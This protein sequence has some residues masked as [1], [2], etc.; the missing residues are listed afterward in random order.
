MRG[1]VF[2]GAIAFALAAAFSAMTNAMSTDVTSAAGAGSRFGVVIPPPSTLAKNQ[3]FLEELGVEWYQDYGLDMSNVPSGANKIALVRMSTNST[4]WTSGQAEAIGALA[5]DAIVSLG[6]ADPAEVRQTATS[7]PGTYWQVSVE[8]NVRAEVTGARFAPV[9]RF[10][11]DQIVNADPTAKIIGPAILNWDFTCIGC[12]GYQSGEAW[13]MEFIGA[14]EALFGEKPP[15]DAW[16]I[17]AYPI[18]WTNTP[19][20]DPDTSNQPTWKGNKVTHSGIV[21]DQLQGMRQY[22]DSIPQYAE[23]PIWA[24]QVGV[25]VGYT[26]WTFE[27]GQIVSQGVYRWDLMSDFVH[28]VLDWLDTN[29]ETDNIGRWLFYIAW[30]D[31]VNLGFTGYM[32]P[33]FF[34]GPGQGASL[35]CLGEVYR[36]RALGLPRLDCDTDG[37]LIGQPVPSGPTPTPTPTATATPTPTPVPLTSVWTLLTL[38]AFFVVLVPFQ[39]WRARHTRHR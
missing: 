29:A 21:I 32:G 25:Q 7:S 36:A 6:F 23:T 9:F 11:R 18:D 39:L 19:N 22:L 4:V 26:G 15:V 5:A 28:E 3:N 27:S 34:D 12:V 35:N 31:I 37:S 30:Q 1:A 14:Y 10:Y 13:L 16:A 24:T 20:N 33:V 38:A 17:D 8:P 2:T